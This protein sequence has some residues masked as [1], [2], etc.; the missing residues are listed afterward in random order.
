MI[1]QS[2]ILSIHPQY[3]AKILSGEK[4]FEFRRRIPKLEV[5]YM[6]V[7][8][9]SPKKKFVAIIEVLEILKDEP[10]MLWEKTKFLS[11]ISYESFKVYFKGCQISYAYKLGKVYLLPSNDF[12]F[13]NVQSFSYLS[14]DIIT[15]Y[16][17]DEYLSIDHRLI[18]ISGINNI[19]KTRVIN[20]YFKHLGYSC[21]SFQRIINLNNNDYWSNNHDD[22]LDEKWSILWKNLKKGKNNNNAI[23]LDG[24]FVL[25]NRNREI[26]NVPLNFFYKIKPVL[27]FVLIYD[28]NEIERLS[29]D[30]FDIEFYEKFQEMELVRG[31]KI[32]QE[33]SIPIKIINC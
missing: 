2:I 28:I 31:K 1:N 14:N 19:C 12:S 25:L 26:V 22:G 15:K 23:V 16:I 24:H 5:S 3:V 33:L 20:K 32:A 30:N 9:T 17:N 11:G 8:E 13:K 29:N 27:I 10:E 18:Y 7:Y 21:L 6:L 4:A